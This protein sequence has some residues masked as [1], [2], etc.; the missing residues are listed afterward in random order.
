MLGNPASTSLDG[1]PPLPVLGVFMSF[2]SRLL[3]CVFF[4]S[5]LLAQSNNPVPFVNQPLV[6]ASVTP[7]A[8]GFTL[9]VNGVGF[10]SGSVV[11]WNGSPRPTVVLSSGSL[12]ASITASDV[13]QETTGWVT[14]VNPSPGVGTSNV[15]YLF[16]RKPS[17]SVAMNADAS[18]SANGPNAV[19]DFNNDGKLDIAVAW[20]PQTGVVE[21]DMYSGKGKGQFAAPVK[22]KFSHV[23]ASVG[24]VLA[25]DFNGDGNLDLA[26]NR[27]IGT[28]DCKTEIFLGNGHGKFSAKGNFSSVCGAWAAA[29][30]NGDGKLDIITQGRI[31]GGCV[32]GV[33]LGNGDEHFST[34]QT[35]GGRTAI[36][37]T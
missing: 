15:A 34:R 32:A 10:V 16:V 29:D 23:L 28:L 25:A 37:S 27:G 19:G 31:N 17:P 11:N 21:I 5:T 20:I 6:P 35:L 33:F 4:C 2:Y 14:V 24:S 1:F 9:T 12:Q 8:K 13:A 22:T 26:V 36:T 30:F 3:A 7:G 18:F